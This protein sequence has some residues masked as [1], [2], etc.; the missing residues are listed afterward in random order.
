MSVTTASASPDRDYS[1]GQNMGQANPI[2]NHERPKRASSLSPGGTFAVA[3]TII[4]STL[5]NLRRKPSQKRALA[6][7]RAD[8]PLCNLSRSFSVD[9]P[10]QTKTTPSCHP[11]IYCQDG[12]S[13]C[14]SPLQTSPSTPA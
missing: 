6:H 13:C 10:D 12:Y 3:V 14:P 2:G 11:I 1:T 7:D 5:N 8:N 9:F 4:A